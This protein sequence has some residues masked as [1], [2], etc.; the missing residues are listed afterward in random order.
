[1]LHYEVFLP[2]PLIHHKFLKDEFSKS[3]Q[4]AIN[5][6]K[7]IRSKSHLNIWKGFFPIRPTFLS[8]VCCLQ[9]L[10]HL[11]YC[12]LLD[13]SSA[14][15]AQFLNIESR[16]KRLNHFQR[17]SFVNNDQT[18]PVTNFAAFNVALSGYEIILLYSLKSEIWCFVSI[19]NSSNSKFLDQRDLEIRESQN[20]PN[21][22]HLCPI[23]CQESCIFLFLLQSIQILQL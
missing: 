11:D 13:Q 18:F 23:N 21:F 19:G 16:R 8:R 4:K 3:N 17:F 14:V 7:Q 15:F 12:Y 2:K 1:M 5:N 10:F 6:I 9:A 22:P 20:L